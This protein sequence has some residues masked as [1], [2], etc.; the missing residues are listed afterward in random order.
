MIGLES[1]YTQER[2]K[3]EYRC[4]TDNSNPFVCDFAVLLCAQ[5]WTA[6]RGYL[7][8]LVFADIYSN[9]GN[10]FILWRLLDRWRAVRRYFVLPGRDIIDL[11]KVAWATFNN[12]DNDRF[13]S[14]HIYFDGS[15]RRHA[16]ELIEDEARF[17]Y[18]CMIDRLGP[19]ADIDGVVNAY[20]MPP[21]EPAQP[22]IE[23]GILTESGEK[24][25]IPNL[26]GSED[27]D[28]WYRRVK[29]G[30]ANELDAAT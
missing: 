26:P 10:N 19:L 17:F 15:C 7:Q 14:A 5:A 21:E 24:R 18:H 13:S 22:P 1:I 23:V 2:K 25:P 9:M 3:N 29:R 11:E 8:L 16:V 20:I 4:S 30:L 12:I 6:T 28:E 27:M